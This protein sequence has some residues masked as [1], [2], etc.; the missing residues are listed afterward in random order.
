MIMPP[1]SSSR[2]RAAAPDARVGGEAAKV[3][4]IAN[5]YVVEEEV[6]SGGM[7]VVYRVRE[8]SSG[9][10]RALKRLKPEA[11]ADRALVEAFEREYQILAGLIHPRIIQ[12]FDY[13]IVDFCAAD[14]RLLPVTFVPLAEPERAIAETRF[15]LDAGERSEREKQAFYSRNFEDLMGMSG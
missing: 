7:G 10:A 14:P 13:G 11:A 3:E 5:R 12:V 1:Q 15:A 6:A 2:W 9:R 8:R 4:Q